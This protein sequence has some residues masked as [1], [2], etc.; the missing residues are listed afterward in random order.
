[1]EGRL[2][3]WRGITLAVLLVGYAGYYLCR[4]NLSAATPLI[5]A[6][7]GK[8]GI[9][10]AAIGLIASAGLLA[11]AVG[12]VVNGIVGDLLGGRVMFLGGMLVSVAATLAFGAST[13]FLTLAVVWSANRFAQSAGW[14]ALVKIASHWFPA[15]LYGTVM[16]TLS[17]S[18]LFG[19]AVGRLVLGRMIAAGLGWRGV[20][21][22]S[23]AVLLAIAAATAVLLKPSPAVIG[24]PEPEG[25]P[26]PVQAPGLRLATYFRDSSF[27]LICVL[28][29]G[30]T[31]IR[32]TF[33]A[34]TPAYLVEVHGLSAAE[35]A[36]RS[37][38]FPLMGGI[39]VL[40]VGLLS[41]RVGTNRMVVALPPLALSAVALALLG[42]GG[43]AGQGTSLALIAAV[44][45]LLIGPYSLLAG[46]MAADL[47]GKGGSATAAGLI[48][49]A[50]YLGGMLSGYAV[51]SLAQTHGWT[52]AFDALAA[53]AVVAIVAALAYW[54]SERPASAA[55]AAAAS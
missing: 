13:G 20:F 19:D 36:Q 9:D 14:S 6:E 21:A 24:L 16:A 28:S 49:A 54:R 5:I 48:D 45:F 35:A 51:G 18:Y 47:G 43:H 27:W 33:N 4:S 53:V 7:L 46:A 40:L 11:Y 50:G 1:M 25:P 39:S 8:A 12:K 17:L 44:A 41:D 32:E 2:R 30:L 52:A 22:A 15:R 34:W 29:F 23:A 55:V 26:E 42:H 31:L 3:L 38:I 10:K 37:A